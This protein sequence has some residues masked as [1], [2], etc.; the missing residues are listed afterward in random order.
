MGATVA[1]I[2]MNRSGSIAGL[3]DCIVEFKGACLKGLKLQEERPDDAYIHVRPSGNIF[4]PAN[5]DFIGQPLY[6]A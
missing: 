5:V 3:S 2:T 6:A 4:E 1:L